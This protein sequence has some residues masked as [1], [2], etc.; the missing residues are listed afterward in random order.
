MG[1]F[2]WQAAVFFTLWLQLQGF[3]SSTSANIAA[4][5]GAG[6]AVGALLG[7]H[8]GDRAARR[9]PDSGRIFTAQASVASGI[10]LIWLVL[11]GGCGCGCGCGRAYGGGGGARWA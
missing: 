3:A 5:F 4:T 1:S 10:P 8:I 7:G 2:P 11:K 6:V 9:L